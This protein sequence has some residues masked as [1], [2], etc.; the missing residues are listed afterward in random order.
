MLSFQLPQGTSWDS[1][2]L[3]CTIIWGRGW[4][5]GCLKG[6]RHPQCFL[7]QV[8]MNAVLALELHSNSFS[9]AWCRTAQI[10]LSLVEGQDGC[11]S[12][13]RVMGW[14]LPEVIVL[15][16]AK[17]TSSKQQQL[18]CLVHYPLVVWPL[19]VSLSLCEN[20][21]ATLAFLWAKLCT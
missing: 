8:T 13:L 16:K 14:P 19:N 5:R 6:S 4:V 2:E 7:K 11:S 20:F 9:K 18:R 12:R 1:S 17:G 10:L 15:W 3:E 21:K